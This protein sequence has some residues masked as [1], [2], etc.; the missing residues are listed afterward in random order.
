M[1]YQNIIRANSKGRD[2]LPEGSA[3]SRGKHSQ[4]EKLGLN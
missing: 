3:T 4:V 1:F 2:K